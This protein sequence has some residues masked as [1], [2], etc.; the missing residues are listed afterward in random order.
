MINFLSVDKQAILA[1][2]ALMPSV[3][4]VMNLA[5]LLRTDLTR[6]L[7]QK[8]HAT[9]AGPIQGI[10]KFTTGGTGHTSIMVSDIGDISAGH[11]PTFIPTVTEVAVIE[12]TP[13]ALLATAAAH[14]APQVMDAPITP[15]VMIPTS[16]VALTPHLTL[17]LWVP[18]TPL[19]RLDP[20]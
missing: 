4:A 7:Y 1:S 17:L 20:V 19:H 8:Q 3:M 5:T 9:T 15:H 11:S 6:F 2:S 16:I 14:A 13:H 10:N 18:L 12:G